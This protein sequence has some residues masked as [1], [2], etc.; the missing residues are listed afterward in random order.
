MEQAFIP[1]S[2]VE[3]A[4]RKLLEIRMGEKRLNVHSECCV[5]RCTRVPE[6][7]QEEAF[8]LFNAW[9]RTQNPRADWLSCGR[10]FGLSD[11]YGRKSG[12]MV[13]PRRGEK[14]KRDKTNI[15]QEEGQD[16]QDKDKIQKETKS[17]VG[18]RRV[19]GT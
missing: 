11:G 19:L 18:G 7:T 4:R 3:H 1:L 12:C 10:G 15:K 16:S 8:S 6:M 14:I 2:E 17:R 5:R 13:E 9:S